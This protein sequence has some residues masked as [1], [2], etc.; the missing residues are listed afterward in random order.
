MNCKKKRMLMRTVLIIPGILLSI[1]SIT[2]SIWDDDDIAEAI[3]NEYRTDNTINTALINIKVI[4][5]IVELTGSLNTLVAKERATEIARSVKGVRSVSNRISVDP[6]VVLSD[7]G[8][9]KEVR[10]ALEEDPATSLYDVTVTVENSLVTLSGMVDSYQARELCRHVAMS[11]EGVVDIFNSVIVDYKIDRDDTAI[12]N[13]IQRALY[14]NVMV[15][16]RLIDVS[17]ING[18]VEL[19]GV[20][21]SAEEKQNAYLNAWVAGVRSV[22]TSMLE[23][24]WREADEHLRDRIDEP[25]SDEEIEKAI[26]DAARYDPRVAPFIVIPEVINGNTTLRG[27]VNNLKAKVAA[28]KLAKNTRGV[29]DVNNEIEVEPDDFAIRPAD[30]LIEASLRNELLNNDETDLMHIDV[31]VSE[32]VVSLRGVVNRFVVKQ[33]AETIAYDVAG[34][35]KVNNNIVVNHPYSISLWDDYPHYYRLITEPSDPVYIPLDFLEI[36]KEI[37]IEEF[38]DPHITR[39]RIRI[40]LGD[41]QINLDG[42][43]LDD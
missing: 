2:L 26:K 42:I 33:E 6:P 36:E 15:D 39:D 37:R 24:K 12:I 35:I 13:E 8:I 10:K 7:N 41:G 11:V 43:I 5:G 16:D 22:D 20:V 38:P 3:Y 1:I 31:D 21:G 9:E 4:D 23:V 34:V 25:V 14:W 40:R 29:A 19:R 18:E 30:S 28:E 27:T 17:A 32:G